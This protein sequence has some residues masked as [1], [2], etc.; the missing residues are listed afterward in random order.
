MET[1]PALL[2]LCEGIHRWPVDSFTKARD[3]ELLMFCLICAWTNGWANN[4]EVGDL[5]CNG[6]RYD[7]TVMKSFT[8]SDSVTTWSR[9]FALLVVC[10]GKTRVADGFPS[11]RS[12][13]AE[14]FCSFVLFK[15][16]SCWIN[17]RVAVVRDAMGS[18]WWLN[19]RHWIHQLICWILVIL[20]PNNFTNGN[21][22]IFTML[23]SAGD[24][25][26][27]KMIFRSHI[28]LTTEIPSYFMFRMLVA[29]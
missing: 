14:L 12:S 18:Q 19:S 7:V 29:D 4:R 10:V 13:Y 1:F 22:E 9:F 27:D 3:A 17:S 16:T 25:V 20:T 21:Q 15:P 26:D 6:A 8:P 2:A 24:I 28:I 11:Q 5:R 23:F